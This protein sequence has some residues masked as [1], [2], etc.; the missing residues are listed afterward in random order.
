MLIS[1]SADKHIVHIGSLLFI[2]SDGNRGSNG[3]LSNLLYL[4]TPFVFG[5]FQIGESE[6]G[7]AVGDN[8]INPVFAE[9]SMDLGDR[10]IGICS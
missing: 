6:L 8:N 7:L 9:Y 4:Y 1:L 5:S 2:R 10:L 3:R